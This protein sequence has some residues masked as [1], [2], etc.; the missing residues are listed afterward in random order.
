MTLILHC[1]ASNASRSDIDGVEVPH[2]TATWNPVRYGDAIDH[3]LE[4]VERELR[5]PVKSQQYGLSKS[6]D[7]MFGVI[8]L[9]TGDAV[10]GLSIGMRQSYNKSLALGLALGAQV[11]V[12]DNL[13]FNSSGYKLVRKNTVNVWRDFQE[14]VRLQAHR[15][16]DNYGSMR[17]DVAKLQATPC[18]E[19]LG[20]EL[21]GVALG[22]GLLTPT[23]ATVAF[24]DWKTARHPEFAEGGRSFWWLY[25]AV[26]E[27][28]KKGAAGHVIDRHVDAHGFMLG[29]A[30]ARA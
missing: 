18:P 29:E 21:L 26:T 2:R 13:A 10:H 30:T 22:Q 1:G 12:C 15:A 20:F 14:L 5:L 17:A 9:D 24:E 25:N 8:T 19:R 3:V 23:Q 16:L 7:Q 28:L 6:G 11:F 27:A 4:V